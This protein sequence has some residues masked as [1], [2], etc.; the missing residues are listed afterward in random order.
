V[1]EHLSQHLVDLT[2]VS[3]TANGVAEFALN[4]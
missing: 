2:H 3:L 4:H 1:A